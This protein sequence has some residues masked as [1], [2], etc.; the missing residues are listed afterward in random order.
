M[1]RCVFPFVRMWDLAR[2]RLFGIEPPTIPAAYVWK[3]FDFPSMMFAW[4]A[5]ALSTRFAA[6]L[7]ESGVTRPA[8]LPRRRADTDP[9]Q[10]VPWARPT[11]EGARVVLP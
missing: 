9:G 8:P 7:R 11:V 3:R 2:K 10:V 6:V 4:A 5:G 1:N